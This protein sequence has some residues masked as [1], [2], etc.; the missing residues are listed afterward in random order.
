MEIRMFPDPKEN[1]CVNA[2]TSSLAL[3]GPSSTEQACS[4]AIAR[5]RNSSASAMKF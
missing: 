1:S 3:C 2:I 5:N 4:N